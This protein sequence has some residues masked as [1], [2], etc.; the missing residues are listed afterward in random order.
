MAQ[1]LSAEEVRNLPV[2]ID[3]ITAGR[4]LGIGRTKSY[5]LARTG[6]FPCRVWRVGRSYR[7][8]T[9]DLQAILGITPPT[10][11]RPSASRRKDK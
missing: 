3:L 2:I 8:R 4:A 1:G 11:S 7:V 5:Q 10:P 9:T 6:D